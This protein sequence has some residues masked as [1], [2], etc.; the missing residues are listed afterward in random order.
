MHDGVAVGV[1]QRLEHS[2]HDREDL[3]RRKRGLAHPVA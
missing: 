2:V 3:R 1:I